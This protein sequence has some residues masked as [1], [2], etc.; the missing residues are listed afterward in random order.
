MEKVVRWLL[1]GVGIAIV[2]ICLNYL[3]LSGR[4][5]SPSFT[6]LISRGELLLVAAVISA[7]AIS[8]LIGSEKKRGIR[9]V[10]AGGGC[11][12]ILFLCAGWFASISADLATGNH[13][14][15]QVVTYNSIWMFMFALISG[16]SCVALEE[17]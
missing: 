13:V 3:T 12:I 14:D 1:F 10:L 11:I 8:R 5:V 6:M 15:A 4:G 2:P 16:G 17:G 9:K 7:E